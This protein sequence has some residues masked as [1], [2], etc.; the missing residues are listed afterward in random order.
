MRRSFPLNK[1]DTIKIMRGQFRGKTGKVL[2]IN[3]K[4]A[5]IYVDGIQRSKRD[6]TKINIPIDPSNVQI[7]AFNLNDKKRAQSMEKKK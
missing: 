6:G 5:K 3:M 7:T 2:I 1:E 4:K